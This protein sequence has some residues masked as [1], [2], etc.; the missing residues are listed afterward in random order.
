LN[1]FLL[2]QGD[3]RAYRP[4]RFLAS[5]SGMV[6]FSSAS[7]R[8]ARRVLNVD[9]IH[10]LL[11]QAFQETEILY[12]NHGGQVFPTVGHDGTEA[13]HDVLPLVQCK[14]YE[15]ITRRTQLSRN[16]PHYAPTAFRSS[17]SAFNAP[18]G[19]SSC[20]NIR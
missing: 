14:L 12:W 10:F 1:V 4:R 11:G 3:L 19:V 15:S 7:F 20:L 9:A 8:A 13:C 17:S 18:S 6:P 2:R 5:S 16:C